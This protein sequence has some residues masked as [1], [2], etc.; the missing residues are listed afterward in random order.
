M[1]NVQ[2]PQKWL[3]YGSPYGNLNVQVKLNISYEGH[4]K[5]F[6]PQT[7]AWLEEMCQNGMDVLGVVRRNPRAMCYGIARLLPRF[8]R[9]RVSISL[10]RK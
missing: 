4:V 9:N 10:V 2:T 1:E 3:I 5:I 8:G 6:C 7:S